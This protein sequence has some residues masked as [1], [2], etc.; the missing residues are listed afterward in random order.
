MPETE[1][2]L[3]GNPSA[4]VRRHRLTEEF[5]MMREKFF[6]YLNRGDYVLKYS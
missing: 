4:L 2:H 3:G 1:V 6:M 5:L